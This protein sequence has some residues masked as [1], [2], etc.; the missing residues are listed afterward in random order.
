MGKMKWFLSKMEA[1]FFGQRKWKHLRHTFYSAE[2]W[3]SLGPYSP[4]RLS[5]KLWRFYLVVYYFLILFSLKLLLEKRKKVY[6]LLISYQIK[7]E[8]YLLIWNVKLKNMLRSISGQTQSVK[9]QKFCFHAFVHARKLFA[10]F[11][12]SG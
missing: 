4:I 10:C 2:R 6:I 7:G 8:T 1:F 5:P 3:C 11:F 12:F 9:A